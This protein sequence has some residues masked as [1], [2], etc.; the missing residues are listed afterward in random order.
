MTLKPR[1]FPSPVFW[2]ALVLATISLPRFQALG[3]VNQP[4]YKAIPPSSYEL[5][6]LGCKLNKANDDKTHLG[7]FVFTWKGKNPVRILTLPQT[8]KKVFYP[9]DDFRVH[10]G[11]GWKTGGGIEDSTGWETI[12]PGQVITFSI[13][14]GMIDVVIDRDKKGDKACLILHS[15]EGEIVSD[16]FPLPLLPLLS[17]NSK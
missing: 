16:E 10:E 9:L 12:Q 5:R 3:D 6:F 2:L 1:A 15:K 13:G 11:S 17:A 4:D 14:M 8:D 7:I